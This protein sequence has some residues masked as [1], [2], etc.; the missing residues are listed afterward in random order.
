[1]IS[2]PL[3]CSGRADRVQGAHFVPLL[4]LVLALP[5]QAVAA[6]SPFARDTGP[7]SEFDASVTL[8]LRDFPDEG[9]LGERRVHPSLA[10]EFEY[11]REWNQGAD[12]FTLVPF[13]RYDVRDDRRTRGDLREA[14]LTHVG[15]GFEIH[16][17]LRRVFWGQTESKHLVDVLNQVDLI[18]NVDEE[19]RLGQPMLNLTLL[20]D[21]GVIEA[22]V[23]PGFRE[24][25][26]ASTDGRFTGPFEIAEAR[27]G[28]RRVASGRVDW[29]L[30]W[31]HLIGEVE[32]G[33]AWFDGTNREPEFEPVGPVE[34]GVPIRLQP[35]YRAMTQASLDAQY[36]RGDWAWKLELLRRGG[37][38]PSHV[39]FVAGFERT[40]IGVFDTRADLGLLAEYLYDDRDRRTPLLSFASDVFLGLR[41]AFNDLADSDLLAGVIVD[42]RSGRQVWSVE[43]GT[44]LGQHWRLAFEGR[45]FRGARALRPGVLEDLTEPGRQWGA[46]ARDDYL[47]FELTRFF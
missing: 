46:I 13:L 37:D 22:Y 25:T 4:L 15:D 26:F 29:A 3:P 24:R 36:I 17:G 7:R 20:R 32:L 12:S 11:F 34:A 39:A 8:Q 40:L 41:L 14:F 27:S 5:L 43:A 16:A 33:L 28:I 9:L 19:D 1:M 18:E 23:L 38:S 21:W 6:A 45:A 42:H 30:R 47:Q 35:R 44:R 2:A 31:S 10:L